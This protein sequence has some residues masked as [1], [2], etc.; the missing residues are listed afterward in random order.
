MTADL[1]VVGS[2]IVGAA[3][4]LRLGQAGHRVAL[5]DG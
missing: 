5:G 1:A 2:G 3:T 4:A